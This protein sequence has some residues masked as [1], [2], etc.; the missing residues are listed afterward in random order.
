MSIMKINNVSAGYIFA[1][2][3]DTGAVI[4]THE[5]YVEVVHGQK[6]RPPRITEA[7]CQE[8][9]I[10]A[11]R[12][13]KNRKVEALI[14]PEGFTLDEN[15]RISVDSERKTLHKT[16]DETRSLADRFADYGK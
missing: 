12:V 11:A 8:I 2:D 1:Y 3:A 7:E 5:K 13:F 9:K 10:E 14:A 6:E 16:A 15:E 4:W